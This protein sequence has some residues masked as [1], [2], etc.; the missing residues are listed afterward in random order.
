MK[1]ASS[2]WR[3]DSVKDE[4]TDNQNKRTWSNNGTYWRQLSSSSNSG[5]PEW[6]DDDVDQD[7]GTFDASGQ[8]KSMK[9]SVLF[10]ADL[11][12]LVALFLGCFFA[13]CCF[14]AITLMCQIATPRLLIS[15]NSSSPQLLFGPPFISFCAEIFQNMLKIYFD[16]IFPYVNNIFVFVHFHGHRRLIYEHRDRHRFYSLLGIRVLHQFCR[17][18]CVPVVK[19]RRLGVRAHSSQSKSINLQTTILLL[20]NTHIRHDR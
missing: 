8:F 11:Y 13:I 7:V 4:G 17:C 5:L 14:I 19:E 3:T 12:Y 2:N 15:E 1:D 9:V 18:A 6:C 16:Q 10:K 20:Y